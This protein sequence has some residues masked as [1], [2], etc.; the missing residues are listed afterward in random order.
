MHG[1]W[2]AVGP[3]DKDRHLA[4]KSD[5]FDK[6]LDILPPP[7]CR[8]LSFQIFGLARDLGRKGLPELLLH[9][10]SLVNYPEFIKD[11]FRIQRI[12]RSL[13]IRHTLKLLLLPAILY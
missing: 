9:A 1:W 4:S 10:K 7:P 12:D 2:L 6:K 8:R 13:L 5:A 3:Q 11:T